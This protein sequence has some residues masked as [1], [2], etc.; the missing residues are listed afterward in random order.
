MPE[1]TADWQHPPHEEKQHWDSATGWVPGPEPSLETGPGTAL[2]AGPVCG[3]LL[4][5]QGK[6]REEGT[7]S[8]TPPLP[9]Q[10]EAELSCGQ[11]AVTLLEGE[12]RSQ[13]PSQIPG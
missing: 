11:D 2:P 10:G 7:R 4:A 8:G 6:G 12:A 3:R 5:G 1:G 13:G 9:P